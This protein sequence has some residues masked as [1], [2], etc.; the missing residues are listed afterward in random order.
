MRLRRAVSK[1]PLKT[2]EPQCRFGVLGVSKDTKG[3]ATTNHC[4]EHS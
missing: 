1:M 4:T 2:I 3:S